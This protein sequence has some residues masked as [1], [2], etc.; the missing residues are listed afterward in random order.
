MAGFSIDNLISK[1]FGGYKGYGLL[2]GAMVKKKK[3]NLKLKL[4]LK[5][6]CSLVKEMQFSE[7]FFLFPN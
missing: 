1:K 3:K 5:F 4:K 6:C 2:F 7:H